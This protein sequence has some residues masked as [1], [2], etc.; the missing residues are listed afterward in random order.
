LANF[1]ARHGLS[2]RQGASIGQKLPKD[3]DQKLD[4]FQSTTNC[5]TYATWT[6][7]QW[8]STCRVMGHFTLLGRRPSWS[9]DGWKLQPLVIFKGVHDSKVNIRGCRVTVQRKG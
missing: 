9:A 1:K 5:M 6:R 7:R 4:I 8:S 2:T 3:A